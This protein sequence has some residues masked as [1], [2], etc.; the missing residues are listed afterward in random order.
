MSR[1]GEDAEKFTDILDAA[2]HVAEM[3]N[4]R[5][6]AEVRARAAPEQVQ[7]PDGSWPITECRT[8]GDDLTPARLST[9]RT[10]CVPCVEHEEKRNMRGLR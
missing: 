5:S 8:C 10:R 9:G 3:H 6:L 1:C 4:Q 7:N 2:A